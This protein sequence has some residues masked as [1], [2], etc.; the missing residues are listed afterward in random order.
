MNDYYCLDLKFKDQKISSKVHHTHL[1]VSDEKIFFQIIDDDFNSQVDTF[2]SMSANALGYFEDNFEIVKT[3]IEIRF[4][5]SKIYKVISFEND[6][7][8]N[9]FTVFIDNICLIRPNTYKDYIGEGKAVLN[10]NGLK[11]VNLFYSYFTNLK[12][13][14][15]FSISRMNGMSDFYSFKEMEFRP[16]LDFLSNEKR[17]SRKFTITKIPTINFKFKNLIYEEILIY[18]K[19]IC[20]FLSF[21][22]GVRI[23][24]KKIVYRTEQDIYILRN[25]AP[26]NKIYI[27][28]FSV[29]F[30]LLEEN[31]NIEKI[32]KTNWFDYFLSNEAKINKAIDNYLHSREV[33]LS[34]A[35]LLL[36]NIIEIFNINQTQ[37]KF[38]F[39]GL[40]QENFSKAYELIRE[41]LIDDEEVNLLKNKWDGLINKISIKPLKSPL[42]ETLKTNN[43]NSLAFGFSFKK[44]KETRDKLTHGS[45]NSIKE[46]DLKLQIYCLRKIAISLILSNLGLK[47]D[48][49]TD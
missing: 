39:N 38:Q 40:K 30:N 27:S 9:Y 12:N 25:T 11:V 31:Y 17:G 22:F 46:E 16:E 5:K 3:E 26:N 29:I 37:E 42:E 13:K 44:L 19:I 23:T 41:S 18:N 36:F 10:E 32:L 28:D 6:E 35:F 14:N 4:E 24:I 49:K 1:F 7:R 45:V 43:I 15:D 8:H 21:C 20:T 34:S 48:L 47:N 33:E 2:Y